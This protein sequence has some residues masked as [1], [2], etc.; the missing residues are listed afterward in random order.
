YMRNAVR[1]AALMRRPVVYVFTH[2]SIGL[3]EDGPTH[4]PV[5]Q[6]A[7]LRATPGLETWRP[8]DAVETA[9]AWKESLLRADGPSALVLSRQ[10][11]PHQPRDAAQL[12]GIARGGYVL[13]DAP[14]GL[15]EAI[16]IAT[17]SEL[18]IAREAVRALNADG[19]R[20]RLVS[21]PCCERFEAEDAAWRESVLPLE[22][23]RR[24]AVE[25]AHADFWSKYTGLDGRVIGMRGF[26]ASAPASAL[27]AHFGFTA[28]NVQAVTRELLDG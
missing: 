4:Q 5:E 13:E 12:A 21:M 1:L 27:M 6:I 24:V 18:G 15:P 8:G 19:R 25:A 23:R 14:G 26:G 16:V 28:A 17:G 3:G 7:N 11:L 10:N 2:D 22:V 9:V 20:V